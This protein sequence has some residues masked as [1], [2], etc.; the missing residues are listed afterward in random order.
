MKRKNMKHTL[1][2]KKG[3][4][5]ITETNGV[6][7]KEETTGDKLIEETLQLIRKKSSEVSEL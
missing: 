1:N 4:R 2:L 5:E 6:K 3:L 7:R